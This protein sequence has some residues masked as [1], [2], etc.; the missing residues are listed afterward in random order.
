MKFEDAKK[1]DVI[2]HQSGTKYTV[3]MVGVDRRLAV[4]N[5]ETGGPI[6]FINEDQ[7][8]Y[9]TGK[10]KFYQVGKTYKFPKRGD[11]WK[12]LDVYEVSKVEWHTEKIKAVAKM[13]TPDGFEDI[14]T[15]T[16]GDYERMVQV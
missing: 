10:D 16:L 6:Y 2:T 1:D 5:A 15:L 8:K 9:Y 11:V 4:R 13:T 14:Q 3:K 12:I 7:L